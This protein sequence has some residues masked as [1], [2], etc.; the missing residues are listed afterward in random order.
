MSEILENIHKWLEEQRPMYLII[1]FKPDGY[2]G[3]P[4]KFVEASDFASSVDEVY[5]KTK[6]WSRFRVFF[7]PK[8]SDSSDYW[9]TKRGEYFKAKERSAELAELERLKKKYKR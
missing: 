3:I 4:R 6:D 7:V 2:K 1:G 8:E 9:I 5:E